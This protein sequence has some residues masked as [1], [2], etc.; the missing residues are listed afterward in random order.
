MNHNPVKYKDTKYKDRLTLPEGCKVSERN[1]GG[2]IYLT[3]SY[4]ADYQTLKNIILAVYPKAVCTSGGYG[5]STFRLNPTVD[6]LTKPAHGIV[7]LNGV[8][9]SHY[10]F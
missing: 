8:M 2:K 1:R 4:P 3:I 9:V 5:M 10:S 6:Y 7:D